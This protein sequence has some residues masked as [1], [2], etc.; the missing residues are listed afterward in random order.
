MD[1]N[2]GRHY[3]IRFK[4]NKLWSFYSDDKNNIYYRKLIEDDRW[5]APYLIVSSVKREFGICMDAD[6]ELHIIC[7]S[8]KGEMLYIHYNGNHWSN[9]VLCEY[10]AIKY[11]IR[12][13]TVF[14]LDSRIHVIFAI[15]ST[16]NVANWSLLH[17]CW[18]GDKWINNRIAKFT[19]NQDLDPFSYSIDNKD[20]HLSYY[21]ISG[22]S[23]KLFHVRYHHDLQKWLASPDN[24][25][26]DSSI[27]FSPQNEL[28]I[29][30]RIINWTNK[31]EI[32]YQNHLSIVREVD[33]LHR[34]TMESKRQWEITLDEFEKFKT[35][36]SKLKG[37]N[38]LKNFFESILH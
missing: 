26:E 30:E 9:H 2:N 3:L 8:Y 19:I 18:Y 29:F 35:D 15:A 36:T 31:V 38:P 13:P 1:P 17:Y 22:D 14:E 5:G 11:E 21:G 10:D 34:R 23:L 37:K 12:Y 32:A 33:E 7:L 20:I 6:G 4:D 25:S 24:P 27:T 28:A 16:K